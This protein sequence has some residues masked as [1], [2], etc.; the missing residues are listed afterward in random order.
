M[1]TITATHRFLEHKAELERRFA[2]LG[3][4]AAKAAGEAAKEG[5]QALAA[6]RIERPRIFDGYLDAFDVVA[7]VVTATRVRFVVTNRKPYARYVEDGREPGRPVEKAYVD[8]AENR[9]RGRVGS[10]YVSHYTGMPPAGIFPD[11]QNDWAPRFAIA[12]DG[13]P[14]R[15]IFRDLRAHADVA[16]TAEALRRNLGPVLFRR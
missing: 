5:A 12:R 1:L 15:H 7:T 6:A 13:I 14:G 10:S 2:D 11:L 4:V 3:P 16:A 8:N 9:R